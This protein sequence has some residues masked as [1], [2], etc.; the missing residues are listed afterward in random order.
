[1]S[2]PG[3]VTRSRDD[4]TRGVVAVAAMVALMWAVEVV[5]L[6]AGDLDAAGIQPR[7]PD[8]LLGIVLAPFLHAGFGHL[9]ANTV[10]F[11]V[12]GATIALAGLARVV[13]VTAIVGLVGGLGTWL[14]AP[15][16]T[17]H[18]GASGLVFGFA[19]YLLAR[20]LVSRRPVHLAVGVAVLLLYGTT[21]LLGLVPASGVSWQGHLFGALG[22][23]AAARMLEARARPA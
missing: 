14:L 11:L 18:V 23:V 19:A 8:G 21:L 5:D 9:L 10:P 4:R 16:G 17:V 2:T 1:V 7:E 3:A 6:V 22:G 13:A 12:L 15:A 20:G